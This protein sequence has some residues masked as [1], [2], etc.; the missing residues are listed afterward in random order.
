M[1]CEQINHKRDR[2]NRL[3]ENSKTDERNRQN[4]IELELLVH[5]SFR[6]VPLA[7]KEGQRDLY[8]I[9]GKT[10]VGV[11]GTTFWKNAFADTKY[12]IKEAEDAVLRL[13]YT[14]VHNMSD[15]EDILQ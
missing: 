6:I 11:Y 14:Y 2:N 8:Y 12:D 4:K 7:G 13:A 15:A 5:G 3:S 9:Q 10:A 1:R